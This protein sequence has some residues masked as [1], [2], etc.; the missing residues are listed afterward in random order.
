VIPI[1]ALLVTGM[2]AA[3][4]P[5]VKA[6]P[7]LERRAKA[8]LENA[9]KALREAKEV[10][11]KAD[12]QQTSALID[13]IKESV[14]LAYSSLKET[15]KSPGRSPKHFK[16]AEIKTRELLRKLDAFQQEMNVADRSMLDAVKAKVQQVHDELLLGVMRRR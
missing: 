12:I 6:E 3:D 10:Y 13:E 15:G 4:L 1:T 8:A 11:N 2:L 7:N 14:E 9:D 16:N 5:R